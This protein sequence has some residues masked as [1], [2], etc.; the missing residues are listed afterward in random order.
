MIEQRAVSIEEA[1]KA[2]S[3]SKTHLYDLIARGEFTAF[4][5]FGKRMVVPVR[6]LDRLL[7][8][9]LGAAS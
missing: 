1:A 4:V 3:V 8:E 6:A 5:K 7:E 9:R 2:L